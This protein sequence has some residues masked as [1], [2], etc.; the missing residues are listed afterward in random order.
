[1]CLSIIAVKN[2]PL[3]IA[4]NFLFRF[5]SRVLVQGGRKFVIGGLDNTVA[6]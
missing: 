2:A 6:G 4:S 3:A 1:M 5:F